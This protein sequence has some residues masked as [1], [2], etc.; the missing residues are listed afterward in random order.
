[1]ELNLKFVSIKNRIKK[2]EKSNPKY[3]LLLAKLQNLTFWGKSIFRLASYLL[4]FDLA[5]VF[6]FPFIYMIITSLKS[7]LD[8]MDITVKWIPRT[9]HCFS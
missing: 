8:I 7:P 6:L 1:M 4:L 5:F 2:L 3:K 9:L